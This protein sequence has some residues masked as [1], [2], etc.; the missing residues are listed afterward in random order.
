FSK[1]VHQIVLPLLEQIEFNKE[2]RQ[3]VLPLQEQTE[4]SKEIRQ[5]GL[6]LQEQIE[7]S[8]EIRQKTHP[9]LISNVLKDLE[10]VRVVILKQTELQQNRKFKQVR[11]EHQAQT[12]VLETEAEEDNIKLSFGWLGAL[13]NV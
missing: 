2:V 6:P 4:F 8:K 5:L 12:E 11:P 13:L 1:E 7:F 10:Q 3:I 9:Q